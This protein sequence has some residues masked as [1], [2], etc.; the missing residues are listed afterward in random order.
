[1]TQETA[2]EIDL[3]AARWA[4]RMDRG[5]LTD[6]ERETFQVWLD[7]D[8]RR[9]GAFARVRAVAMHTLRAKALGPQF[10]PN[11]FAS[12]APKGASALGLSRRGWL[13]GGAAIAASIAGAAIVGFGVSM[14]QWFS[15]RKGEMRVVSLEDGSVISLN[16]ATKLWIDFT[17]NRRL[18][19]LLDGEALFDVAHDS[20]RPFVVTSGASRVLAAET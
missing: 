6:S 10:D 2:R 8:N 15:T 5:D 11:S 14:P 19:Y 20:R 1:M 7:G 9:P 17:Q 18:A 16:S 4:A 12:D 3:A 13:F